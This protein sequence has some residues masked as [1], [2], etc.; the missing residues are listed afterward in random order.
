MIR[1]GRFLPWMLAGALAGVLPSAGVAQQPDRP[2]S[3]WQGTWHHRHH[4]RAFA[5]RHW[6]EQR[7][8]RMDHRN[9]RMDHRGWRME[10][11]RWAMEHRWRHARKARRLRHRLDG[12][13]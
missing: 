4:P 5:R 3:E 1:I 13:I 7:G 6:R 10:H 12:Y 8:W 11:R 9:W 2:R